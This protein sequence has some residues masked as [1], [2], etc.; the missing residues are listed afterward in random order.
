MERLTAKLQ[1]NYTQKILTK[2]V[3]GI[4]R[5]K[6]DQTFKSKNISSIKEDYY[7]TIRKYNLNKYTIISNFHMS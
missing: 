6:A 5:V 2:H 3:A 4:A 7:I 1:K